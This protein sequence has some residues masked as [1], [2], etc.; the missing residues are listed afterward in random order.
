[1]SPVLHGSIAIYPETFVFELT[2]TRL[3]KSAAACPPSVMPSALIC[4]AFS[5]TAD[6]PGV[7]LC[8]V[9]VIVTVLTL[10]GAV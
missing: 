8:G 4:T 2:N 7:P 9:A 3:E 10:L 5:G 6:V 1:M